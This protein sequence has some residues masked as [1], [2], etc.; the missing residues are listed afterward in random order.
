MK[1]NK[2]KNS[3]IIN[4]DLVVYTTYNVNDNNNRSYDVD[5]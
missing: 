3:R 1:S 5:I 2:P 4:I